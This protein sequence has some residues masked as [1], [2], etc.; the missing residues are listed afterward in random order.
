MT[1]FRSS[2]A[3]VSSENREQN[4]LLSKIIA[5]VRSDSPSRAWK[6]WRVKA[7]GGYFAASTIVGGEE[8]A[9]PERMITRQAFY[10]RVRPLFAPFLYRFQCLGRV[11]TKASKFIGL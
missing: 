4:I 6:P 1:F 3:A 9:Q 10:N 5:A 8:H 7:V 2:S 11:T